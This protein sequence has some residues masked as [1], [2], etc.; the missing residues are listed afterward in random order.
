MDAQPSP[1]RS[2]L[3]RVA[4]DADLA[5]AWGP[6]FPPAVS[7]PFVLGLAEVACHEVVATD[8][9]EGEVTV[10]VAA[11]VEHLAPSPV[12]SELRAEAVLTSAEGRRLVFEVEVFQGSEVVARVRHERARALT[13]RILDRLGRS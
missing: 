3:T 13:S 4:T 11:T 12:G 10:G 2:S 5:S 8:L 7:T 9:N 1:A 6:A